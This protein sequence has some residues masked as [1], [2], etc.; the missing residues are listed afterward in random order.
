MNKEEIKE[1][2]KAEIERLEAQV[3]QLELEEVR[4][5]KWSCIVLVYMITINIA[6]VVSKLTGASMYTLIPVAI[7]LTL[8]GMMIYTNP[9][10]KTKQNEN[11]RNAK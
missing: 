10:N 6:I 3:E 1:E 2:I 8:M 5:N 9:N 7:G 4:R 11:D